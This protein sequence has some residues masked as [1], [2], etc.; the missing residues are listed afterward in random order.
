MLFSIAAVEDI[1][2]RLA[3]PTTN[4]HLQP[5]IVLLKKKKEYKK[6]GDIDLMTHKKLAKYLYLDKNGLS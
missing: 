2:I 3:P 5:F 6:W 1:L 4:N